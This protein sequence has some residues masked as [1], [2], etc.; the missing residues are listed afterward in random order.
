[1]SSA[2]AVSPISNAG[3]ASPD[4]RAERTAQMRVFTVLLAA[5]GLILAFAAVSTASAGASG[6]LVV[7]K[8]GD[9][10]SSADTSGATPYASPEADAMFEYT[11]DNTLPQTGWTAFPSVT[12]VDGK[13]SVELPNGIWFVRERT[14]GSGFSNYGPVQALAFDPTSGSP[15]AQEPYVARVL[16]EE[17][18]TTY[19][20]PH[21]AIDSD[22]D[23]WTPTN[24]GSASNNGSPFLNVRNNGVEPQV[25]GTNILLVLDRSGSIN[26]F[27]NSY[28][29]A[30]QAFVN[31]LDGTPVQIGIISFSDSTNSYSPATG[32]PS[33]YLAPQD[34]SNPGS[35]ALLNATITNIYGS[36]S[37]GTDWDEALQAAAAAKGFTPNGFTGQTANPDSVVFITDGNPTF[38]ETDQGGNGSDVDLFNLT[39]GMA[40]ANLVK[41]Q[42]SRPGNKVHMFAV[43]VDNGEGSSPTADNLK[44]VSGPVQGVGGDFATPTI[45]RLNSFLAQLAATQCGA[46]V[47]VRKHLENDATNQTGWGYTAD[48]PRPAFSPTYLDGDRY[49][50]PN[51][52]S[53]VVET[54]TFFT[55]LPNTPT[56]VTASEDAGGQPLSDFDLTGVVCRYD[57]Y[58]SGQIAPGNLSGLAYSLD[59]NRGDSVYCTFTNNPVTTLSVTKT[60]NAGTINAGEDAEFTIAVENTGTNA[61][62]SATLSDQLPAPGSGPWTVSQ[63]PSGGACSVSGSNLLTCGFNDIP[64]GATRTIRVKTT[65]SFARCGSYDNPI[66]T[67]SADNAEDASDSGKIN[68]RKP[69]LTVTKTGNGSIKSGQNVVFTIRTKNGGPGIAKSVSVRDVL[70]KG[71]AGPWAIKAQSGGNNCSITGRDLNCSFGDIP[72]GG[73]RTVTVRARTS[74]T[75]CR[76]Y[77]NTAT[78]TADNA[79]KSSDRARVRCVKPRLTLNKRANRR[80]VAPGGKVIYTIVVRNTRRGSVARNLKICDR[81]P[82]RMTVVRKGS[83]FFDN[84][85]LCWKIAKL[86]FSKRGRSFTYVARVSGDAAA[87]TK[88]RNVV[89]MGKLTDSKTV[90]VK[91]P[92]VSP[93]R[94]T[95]VAG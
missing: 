5:L 4:A 41:N 62:V 72:A 64:A 20:Y 9:R 10:T 45:A 39:A 12:A 85:R 32:N 71:T 15:V 74:R 91:G 75:A 31:K 69:K 11:Q 88:L 78:A 66:A 57:D 42:A 60:P 89:V 58:D 43:G 95:A 48:D 87:G 70:P 38:N 28:E 73:S 68:C 47:F 80:K 35:A 86:P 30:A 90:V 27:Q 54:G 18:Q 77:D 44:V 19:A 17:G 93:V 3:A 65:T 29:A 25:C 67:A 94:G 8:G 36:P 16:I 52:D 1:M 61:A 51:G 83:G 14:G 23:A 33:Y 59:V 2:E 49:T 92:R 84:G 34:L 82:A 55:Q 81:L 76:L 50:H 40:S 13:A 6:T 46:R 56:T 26:S 7:T 21:S 22:P 79:P 53:S 24:S 63:Q 37:G